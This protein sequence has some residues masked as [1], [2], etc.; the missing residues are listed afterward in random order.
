RSGMVKQANGY[1][2]PVRL[3]HRRLHG[4][5]AMTRI[6][7]A[8]LVLCLALAAT[9]P[10]VAAPGDDLRRLPTAQQV[11]RIERE[12]AVQSR[13]RVI[14]DDQL[15][16]YLAQV[17]RGWGMDQVHKDPSG[18]LRGQGSR[19][20]NGAGWSGATLVCSSND[21]RRRECHTPFRGR[22][23]LVENISGT[24]CVEGRNFGGG[25]GT[26]WVDDRSEERR[27]GKGCRS[28][29]SPAQETYER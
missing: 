29:G 7:T 25:N 4:E 13:G 12:Y 14:P 11:D 18:S 2:P 26:M 15:D 23:V 22:P 24:R 3:P 9:A 28:G 1:I 19:R 5:L 17:Q 10:A 8:V 16:Y 27:V 21:R 20:W 6:L